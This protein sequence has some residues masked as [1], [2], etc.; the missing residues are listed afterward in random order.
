MNVFWLHRNR[1]TLSSIIY[2]ILLTKHFFLL[3]SN[4]LLNITSSLVNIPSGV[5]IIWNAYRFLFTNPPPPPP[6]FSS[7]QQLKLVHWGLQSS[8]KPSLHLIWILL[9][10][11]L[12][13]SMSFYKVLSAFSPCKPYENKVKRRA[14][15]VPV[16]DNKVQC[17]LYRKMHSYIIRCWKHSIW[18]IFDWNWLSGLTSTNDILFFCIRTTL[19]SNEC[20]EEIEL[21]T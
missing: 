6:F 20:L 5:H 18:K 2:V 16:G 4:V 7:L 19:S 13:L 10:L 15:T 14:F 3:W 8:V 11:F 1:H 9:V 21:T 12:V 17:L